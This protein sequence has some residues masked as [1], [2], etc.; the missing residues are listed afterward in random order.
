MGLSLFQISLF[1]FILIIFAAALGEYM[2]KVFKGERTFLSPILMPIEKSLYKLFG[3]DPTIDMD[4]KTFALNLLCFFI[5]GGVLLFLLEKVQ[6]FLPLNPQ[7]LTAMRW[8][9]ALNSAISYITNTNWQP[10]NSESTVSYF[11]QMLGMNLQNF[12]SAGMGITVAIA[13]ING[14]VRKNAYGIGNFWVILTRSI[15]YIL[16]PLAIVLSL[17]LV[18]QGAVQN[19]H[20]PVHAT[21]LEGKEQIIAQGPAA[22]QIAIKHLGTNGGGFFNANSAHPYENPTPLSDY[23]EVLALLLIAAAFPFTF[24]A[25]INNRKQGIAIFI[26]MLALFLISLGIVVWAELH[27]NPFLQKIGVANGINMEG[28][29]VRLGP[30]A[31]A[32]F[33]NSA[34]ATATGAANCAYDSLMPISGMVMIFNMAI[35]E[36]IFGGIGSGFVDMLMYAILSMFLIGLMVGR[37]PELYGKKLDPFIMVMTV[38]ALL[39]PCV[40]K[41]IFDAIAISTNSGL[42]AIGNPG[43]HGLSEVMYAFASTLGNNGSAFAGLHTNTPFYN[44]TTGIAMLIGRL[45]T[46]IPALA[47]AGNLARKKINPPAARFP[48]ASPMF[49]ITLV[50]V[51][52]IVGALT[53]FP[54]LV[55]GPVIE[56]LY[57]FSG[58][59]F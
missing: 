20:H 52:L 30:L 19:L 3:I 49:I 31:S 27:G 45:F 21:T 17:V 6:Y 53:F 39:F 57:I 9:T 42:S 28:K 2:A 51:V 33:A 59:L 25:L 18:S 35:G 44:I 22:S 4:W 14:F 15:I 56:H 24:G 48:T 43:A 23:L 46:I 47:I 5:V 38:I 50:G 7:K 41:L 1:V 29:E 11:T 37:T 8:D 55:I 58:H 10:Y 13:L 34:T 40:M 12:L 54:V 32:I 26:A 36:V 16:L